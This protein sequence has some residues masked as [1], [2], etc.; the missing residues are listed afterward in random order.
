M[1]IYRKK[2]DVVIVF[3]VLLGI[4]LFN[5]KGPLAEYFQKMEAKKAQEVSYGLYDALFHKF[6]EAADQK[7]LLDGSSFDQVKRE[8]EEYALRGASFVPS[9]LIPEYKIEDGDCK[10][11]VY[12]IKGDLKVGE[13]DVPLVFFA[14]SEGIK[15]FSDGL[16]EKINQ[17]PIGGL[18]NNRSYLSFGYFDLKMITIDFGVYGVVSLRRDSFDDFTFYNH[19]KVEVDVPF[20][21]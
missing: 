5:P 21:K 10:F 3:C 12:R 11:Y 20:R 1:K 2:S 19:M 6:D 18:G 13:K 9:E 4:S 16:N 17:K 8:F 15:L 7:I 14:C